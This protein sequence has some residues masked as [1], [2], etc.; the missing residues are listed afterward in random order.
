MQEQKN[1]II[2]VFTTNR[3]PLFNSADENIAGFVRTF[4]GING[5]VFRIPVSDE[6][7]YSISVGC[8]V[9]GG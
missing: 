8:F 1:R 4:R 6:R 3:N 7:K 9:G 2:A 5:V